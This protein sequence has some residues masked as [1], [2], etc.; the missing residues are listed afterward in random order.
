MAL[1]TDDRNVLILLGV[2]AVLVLVYSVFVA[3]AP[4]ELLGF[5]L[6]LVFLYLLWRFV[7]AHERMADA[8]EGTDR[9][10]SADSE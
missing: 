10:D 4:L 3:R 9:P 1:Q 2:V 7:R 5:V 8:L 6:P